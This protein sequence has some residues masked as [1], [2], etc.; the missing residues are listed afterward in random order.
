MTREL[1]WAVKPTP[2]ERIAQAAREFVR[3]R[4]EWALL[5]RA[6]PLDVDAALEAKGCLLAREAALVAAVDQ[7]SACP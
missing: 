3:A 1:P 7:E 2:S 5:E 4:R 6:V